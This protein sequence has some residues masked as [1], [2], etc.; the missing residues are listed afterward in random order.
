MFASTPVAGHYFI[1]LLAGV[2][3]AL[4]AI[5]VACRLGA[6]SI[7]AGAEGGGF[8]PFAAAATAA[9]AARAEPVA[10]VPALGGSASP[11]GLGL[12][13]LAAEIGTGAS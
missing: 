1:D 4:V 10:E 12:R 5:V 2:T 8:A 11:R 13:G 3:V 7:L 6:R 9:A